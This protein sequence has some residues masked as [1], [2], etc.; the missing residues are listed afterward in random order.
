MKRQ[1]VKMT[2][3]R[4]VHKLPSLEKTCGKW[5]VAGWGILLVLMTVLVY[6]PATQCGYV[7][8]D[9]FYVTANPLLSAPDGLQRIWFSTDSPSQYF[10]LVYTSFRFE[11]GLWELEPF[12][13][14]LTNILLHGVNALL[15]WLL[16]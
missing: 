5:V 14:H 8:D 16:L 2:K 3:R 7:W 11:Y 6:L 10:P 9:D 1:K 12:G 13:Y 15:L 4:S